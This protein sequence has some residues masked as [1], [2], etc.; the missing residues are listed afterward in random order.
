MLE[1]GGQGY[2]LVVVW[3]G[4]VIRVGGSSSAWMVQVLV[5]V[6][7]GS[8]EVAYMHG[9]SRGKHRVPYSAYISQV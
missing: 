4:Q 1:V 3:R 8:V 6:G 7:R 5:V 2:R 9:G